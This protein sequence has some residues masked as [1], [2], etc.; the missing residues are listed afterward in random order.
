M[1]AIR[2]ALQRIAADL[3]TILSERQI[4]SIC[5]QVGHRWRERQLNPAVTVW[6]FILQILHGNTACAHVPRLGGQRVSGSAYCQARM[7]LPVAVLRALLHKVAAAV[8]KTTEERGR[9]HGHRTFLLD[10]SSCSMPDTPDLQAAFGQPCG[11]RAGCGF[12]VAHLLTLFDAASG[13]IIDLLASSWRIHDLKRVAEVHPRLQPGDV[14]VGDR[15]FCSYGHVALLLQQKLHAVLRVH[16]RQIVDFRPH[17]PQASSRNAKG[18]PRSEWLC[19]L[20]GEDQLVLWFK[21]RV[22]ARWMSAETHAALPACMVVREL[23]YALARAGFRTRH[24]TLVTT[25]LDPRKYAAEH[26]AELYGA[27]WQVETNLRHLKETLG[28]KVL[29]SK[30]A[31]GVQKELL[32]FALVYN[33]VRAVMLETARR[34]AVEPDRVSFIDALRWL[35][36]PWDSSALGELII[37]PHRPHRFEPRVRKR[38][39]PQYALLTRPRAELRQ[40][41]LEK[42]HAA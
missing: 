20:G 24:I 35:R 12:P 33:L 40:T 31:A 9:W 27:R 5:R 18:K 16:Q 28:M 11:Q 17:R 39:P 6:W 8:R 1:V 30:T 21:P 36:N 14:L 34:R 2:A 42:A 4:M 29:H 37:N 10:G 23:R 15:A 22:G 13:M 38:R 26:L 7:R 3:T 25:L 32:V 41:L 19:S